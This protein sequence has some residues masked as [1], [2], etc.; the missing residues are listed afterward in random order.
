M[1]AFAPSAFRV[2]APRPRPGGV[3]PASGGGM[4]ASRV[5]G[6]LPA[7]PA[8][9]GDV[10]AA[11][12]RATRG[13]VPWPVVAGGLVLVL[14]AVC[15]AAAFPSDSPL[16][17]MHAGIP[18]G[19]TRWAVV[20]GVA[21]AAA[22]AAYLAG[23]WLIS[24][25]GARLAAVVGL[26]ALIQ[27]TPIVAPVMLSTDAWQYWSF[28]RIAVVHHGNPYRDVPA[29]FP[30]DPSFRL[31][32]ENWHELPSPYGPAFTL[33]SEPVALV[34]GDSSTIAG[35]GFKLA[36][37]AAMLAIIAL[38]ALVATRAAF[39][40]AFV[41][42]SPLVAFQSAGSGHNDALMMAALLGALALSARG[43]RD[44]AGGLWAVSIFVK[45]VP[46]VLLPLY[47]LRDRL[48][49]RRLGVAGFGVGVAAVVGL[50]TWSFGSSWLGAV[51][52][53]QSSLTG[54]SV[55]NLAVWHRLAGLGLPDAVAVAIPVAVFGAAYLWLL[56]RAYDGRPRYGLAAGLL[57]VASPAL[58]PW[59]VLWA[60][61][62]SALDDDR[63]AMGIALAFSVYMVM[64]VGDVGSLPSLLLHRG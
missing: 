59:Y 10:P 4:D 52:P 19:S 45:W 56:R 37:A 39:A 42:W 29:A 43:R 22:F 36:A 24:R 35:L 7:R 44:A 41:G 8:S 13:S 64:F 34:A 17:A 47:A 54:E 61:A 16:P 14:V 23:L 57:L 15:T 31:I 40:V 6:T 1:P 32:G 11:G 12:V 9:G 49:W 28:G 3:V 5:E 18:T 50:A 25:H 38:T 60:I 58:Q 33:A 30:D 51:F 46:L 26:A 21:Q 48:A 2:R 63:V 62:T 20:F 27:L 53:I 55:G